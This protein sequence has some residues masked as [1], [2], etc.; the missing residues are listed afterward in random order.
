V[1]GALLDKD[2]MVSLDLKQNEHN[3]TGG[4][5]LEDIEAKP[6]KLLDHP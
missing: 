2:L 5:Y 4:Y 6:A 1:I 3:H